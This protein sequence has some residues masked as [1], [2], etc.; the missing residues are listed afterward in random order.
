MLHWFQGEKNKIYLDVIFPFCMIQMI[1][2]LTILSLCH[3]EG[4]NSDQ[5][6]IFL[7][8]VPK[9]LCTMLDKDFNTYFLFIILTT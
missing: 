9:P 4:M 7:K 3:L 6:L 2:F 1:K 8:I 5:N